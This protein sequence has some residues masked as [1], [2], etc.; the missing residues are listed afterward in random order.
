M[1]KKKVVGVR[2]SPFASV[3]QVVEVDDKDPAVVHYLEKGVLAEVK[4]AKPETI[5]AVLNP[6]DVDDD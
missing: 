4:N 1:A 6:I 3:A 2:R 5:E